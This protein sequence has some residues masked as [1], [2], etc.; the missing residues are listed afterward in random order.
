[1][2]VM[3]FETG[4]SFS[5]AQKS[6]AGSSATGLIQFMPGTAIGLG[7]TIE[8]LALMSGVTQ[9]D[10]VE[11]HFESVVHS[12]AMPNLGDVYMAV[13]L[14]SA[15]GQLDSHVLFQKP[16]RAYDQN[17]GLDVNRNGRVT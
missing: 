6:A 11:K 3:A 13:L 9:L 8:K 12:R 14:P 16:S 1:M 7:T 17:E 15:L 10:F 4:E 5:P 2:A